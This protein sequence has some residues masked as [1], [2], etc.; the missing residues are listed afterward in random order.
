[1]A[2]MTKKKLSE[3]G[4]QNNGQGQADPEKIT[5]Q[6]M[7]ELR[8]GG[9]KGHETQIKNSVP[10]MDRHGGESRLITNV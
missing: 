5:R 10:G 9:R 7:A 2:K 6:E 1:M 4:K 3:M 8:Q